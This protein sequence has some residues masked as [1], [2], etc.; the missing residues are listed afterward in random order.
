MV[1]SKAVLLAALV[2]SGLACVDASGST[3]TP[4]GTQTNTDPTDL[5]GGW[6]A[7]IYT[8]TSKAN[9]ATTTDL[10]VSGYTIALTITNGGHI[11]R[12]IIGPVKTV[13]DT[14]SLLV[15]GSD[16]KLT[17]AGKL[18]TG[19]VSRNNNTMTLDLTGA[20]TVWDFDL[21]GTDE[22]ALLH[23]KFVKG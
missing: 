5:A 15:T 3:G 2:V 20:G 22:L 23:A 10:V 8:F 17:M 6:N 7:T 4:D 12:T 14:G 18:S 1:P 13:T 11:S 19:T 16:M 21:D 9:S